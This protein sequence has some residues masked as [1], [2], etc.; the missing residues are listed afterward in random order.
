MNK[1]ILLAKE[2]AKIKS[3]RTCQKGKI[4]KAVPGEGNPNAKIMFVGEAPG[5]QEAKTGRPF[6]GRS[7][8]F[9]RLAIAKIGLDEKEVYITSPVKYLPK[10]GTPS[11]SDIIHGAT[12]LN[13]QLE[14][15][16]P[17]IIVLLGNVAYK[18][19][20]DQSSAVNSH[21]GKVVTRDGQKYFV[22]FHPASALRFP[23]TRSLMIKDF[24]KLKELIIS[25]D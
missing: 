17:K 10:R 8:K 12:H 24:S 25:E 14:I 2:E 7:G 15:I 18:A 4:G 5:R 6:V 1:R 16:N 20:I 9:L 19:L 21:H 23:R 22:T 3:C 11:R 13:R